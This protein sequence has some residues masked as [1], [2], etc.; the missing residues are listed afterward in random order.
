MDLYPGLLLEKKASGRWAQ[1]AGLNTT[2][3]WLTWDDNGKQTVVQR[4]RFQRETEWGE[5]IAYQEE[6]EGPT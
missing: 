5:V 3:V 4:E 2:H 1:V 6:G